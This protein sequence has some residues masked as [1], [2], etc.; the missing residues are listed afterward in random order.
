M[1][2]DFFKRREYEIRKRMELIKKLKSIVYVL[3]ICIFCNCQNKKELN[4]SSGNSKINKIKDFVPNEG[5]VIQLNNN[6]IIFEEIVTIGDPKN[7]NADFEI[8]KIDNQKILIKRNF[9]ESDLLDDKV[10]YFSEKNIS[11]IKVTFKYDVVFTG[12]EKNTKNLG[13]SKDTTIVLHL[14]KGKI[15]IPKFIDF[16]EYVWK[17]FEKEEIFKQAYKVGMDYISVNESEDVYL[18]Y[19]DKIKEFKKDKRDFKKLEELSID[20]DYSKFIIEFLDENKNHTEIIYDRG[21]TNY[22]N[23]NS[24]ENYGTINETKTLESIKLELSKYKILKEIR[25]DLNKD[26]KEDIIIVFE[27]KEFKK[28]IDYGSNLIDSPF[29]IMINNGDNKYFESRNKNIIYT[30]TFNCPN[31]GLKKLFVKDNYFTVEQGTC[32]EFDRLVKDN[33][34]FK[35]N[36]ETD[37]ITL[38][39]YKRSLFDRLD[40]SEFLPKSVTLNPDHFGKI[41]FKNYD[42]KIEYEKNIKN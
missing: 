35:Y 31:F 36:I 18:N 37:E 25:C 40:N 28:L 2:N 10:V 34:T 30:A 26:S 17:K 38:D 27:P 21:F 33:I 9:L 15:K 6:T 11:N 32:D 20:I 8:T 39:K 3:L 16:R 23:D 4:L 22:I 7:V 13:F 12:D 1:G 14:K 24:K 29:C 41:L 19:L 42:S 5:L